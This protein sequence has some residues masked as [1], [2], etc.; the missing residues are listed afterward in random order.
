MFLKAKAAALL[1]EYFVSC[2]HDEGF[3]FLPCSCGDR[4]PGV[5]GCNLQCG[6]ALNFDPHKFPRGVAY[7]S[8]E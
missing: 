4:F 6:F 8:G 1:T 5:W 3:R 7:K 2:K